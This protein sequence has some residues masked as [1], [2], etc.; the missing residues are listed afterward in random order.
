[1]DNNIITIVIESE[2]KVKNCLSALNQIEYIIN[3]ESIITFIYV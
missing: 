3:F 2:R 1:M